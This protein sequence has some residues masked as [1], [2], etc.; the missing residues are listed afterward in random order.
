VDNIK[1]RDYIATMAMQVLLAKV[2]Q[3]PGYD[4]KAV[5]K[6]SYTIAD[7]MILESKK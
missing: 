5:V 3:V 7:M 6:D 4:E 1:E 2:G